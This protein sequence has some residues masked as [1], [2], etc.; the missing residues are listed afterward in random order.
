MNEL[1]VISEQEVLGSQFRI[2]GDF[3]N[4]LFLAKDVAVR[5]EHSDVSTMLKMVSEEE[6]ADPNNV[7]IR[8]E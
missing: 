3:D 2:Y 1:K 8:S 6:K 7:C 4:P 5:I